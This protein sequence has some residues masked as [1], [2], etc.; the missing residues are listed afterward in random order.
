MRERETYFSSF[1]VLLR[2]WRS[3]VWTHG[4]FQ[5]G[6]FFGFRIDTSEESWWG[7]T[8]QRNHIII[9]TTVITITHITFSFPLR[10]L[11]L[12]F[13]WWR[14]N[15]RRGITHFTRHPHAV[16]TIMII[17]YIC[18]LSFFILLFLLLF[19]SSPA[20]LKTTNTK[21][22]GKTCSD[23]G[24]WNP[25]TWRLS[26]ILRKIFESQD[27][28]YDIS[29]S[30]FKIVKTMRGYTSSFLLVVLVLCSILHPSLSLSSLDETRRS[31]NATHL[32]IHV[33]K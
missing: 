24:S 7:S 16:K 20:I 22:H 15:C 13:E 9:T 17:L 26:L 2:R 1:L 14:W 4:S 8:N 19:F 32:R 11:N 18:I 10:N 28:G 30:N 29:F 31:S 3:W 5:L 27:T 12:N 33:S 25:K 23:S 6:Y 21:N